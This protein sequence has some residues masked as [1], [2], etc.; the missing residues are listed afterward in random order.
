MARPK[1]F[2]LT[3]AIFDK[4]EPGDWLLFLPNKSKLPIHFFNK[5]AGVIGILFN[6]KVRSRSIGQ[7]IK[8]K[9]N[10]YLIKPWRMCAEKDS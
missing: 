8:K 3:L 10:F 7:I 9:K 1:R 4:I 2:K 5:E 6:G